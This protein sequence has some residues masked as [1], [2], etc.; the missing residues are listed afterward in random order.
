METNM[1]ANPVEFKAPNSIAAIWSMML[2]GLG[3]LMK[4]RVMPG[5]FWAFLV[6]G[7]YYAYFWPGLTLHALC[8]LDAGFYKGD[9]SFL[10]LDNWF[11]RIAFVVLVLLLVAYIYFR[12][13]Y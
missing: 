11:K 9:G 1:N 2:P 4:G 13:I 6:A 10:A 12:N 8:I 3:Q 7:G 5:I